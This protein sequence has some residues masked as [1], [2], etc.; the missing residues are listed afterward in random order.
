MKTK[1]LLDLSAKAEAGTQG[2]VDEAKA[3]LLTLGSDLVAVAGDEGR[4]LDD[5]EQAALKAAAGA[6]DKLDAKAAQIKASAD[7]MARFSTMVPSAKASVLGGGTGGHGGGGAHGQIPE[8]ARLNFR[9]KA[10]S[11]TLVTKMADPSGSKALASSGDILTGT[12]LDS[13]VY[14]QGKVSTSALAIL[15]VKDRAPT[16][17]YLRQTKRDNRA[18]P[19]ALGDLKPT[20][21]YGLTSI[22][23]KLEVIAHVAEPVHEY[24]LEDMQNLGTFVENEM[25]YGLDRAVEAQVLGG[26]GVGPNLTGLL[27]TSGVQLQAFSADATTTVRKGL[28]A[29]E[30]VG[31]EGG[32]IILN[33]LAWEAIELSRRQDGTPDLGS[34]L[35]VDRAAQRLWG[36]RIAVSTAVPVETGILFDLGALAVTT[37]GN[38]RMQWSN[39]VADDFGRNQIRARN[40][41]RFGLD[42]YQPQGIVKLALAA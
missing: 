9:A 25:M 36:L 20:S 3:R 4:E 42:V 28:T 27:N 39:S 38:V 23:G 21:E 29:L 40:E 2:H 24:W 31:Y 26:D 13:T 37:D 22:D 16:Y 6:I 10:A 7:I 33:P 11:A 18:A 30:M 34:S 1:E 32:G 5:E 15:P 41:G 35:P 14:E 8:G 19:V 12:P 17:T